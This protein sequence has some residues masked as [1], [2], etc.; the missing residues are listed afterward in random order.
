MAECLKL[1]RRRKEA[2]AS[3]E[4]LWASAPAKDGAHDDEQTI[5][6]ESQAV[7]HGDT[8]DPNK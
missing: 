4:N 2:I 8:R 1:E 7:R 6:D 3:M 5:L